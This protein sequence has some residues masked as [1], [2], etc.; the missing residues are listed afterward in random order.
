LLKFKGWDYE[1]E[2]RVLRALDH[3]LRNG[4]AYLARRAQLLQL[5]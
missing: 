3:D 5:R 2:V 4:R 1:N